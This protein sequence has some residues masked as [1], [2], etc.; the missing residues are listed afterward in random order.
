MS[1]SIKNTIHDNYL[2]TSQTKKELK[3]GDCEVMH[4]RTSGIL[5]FEKKGNAFLYSKSSIEDYKN[6]KK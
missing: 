1:A 6:I 2:N 4:L 5:K 3:M